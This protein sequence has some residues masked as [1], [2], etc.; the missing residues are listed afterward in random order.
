MIPAIG[1]MIAFYIITRML[2][3]IIKKEGEKSENVVVIIFAA[4][5]ILVAILGI[6]ILL[7]GELNLPNYLPWKFNEKIK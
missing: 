3:L 2:S 1:Y 7:S 5:T 6:I 4:V